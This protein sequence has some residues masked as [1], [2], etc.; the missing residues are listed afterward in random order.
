MPL[1]LSVYFVAQ[2]S[3]SDS[4]ATPNNDA[5][6]WRDLHRLI[7]LHQHINLT[8][9]HLQRAVRIMDRAGIG[10]TVNLGTGTVT[11]GADGA[12]IGRASCRERV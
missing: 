11:R 1:L 3:E 4:P 8:P 2:A 6:T 9:E 5:H 7:D 12:Q 10:L